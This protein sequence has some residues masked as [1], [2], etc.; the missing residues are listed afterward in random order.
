MTTGTVQPPETWKV[1]RGP[2]HAADLR[3]GVSNIAA[4]HGLT[5]FSPTQNTLV[6]TSPGDDVPR[7]T[8]RWHQ[9]T[10]KCPDTL[11]HVLP[12]A[13]H[14]EILV[15][16]S[17]GGAVAANRIETWLTR[18]LRRLDQAE[19]AH[20]VES[21]PVLDRYAVPS[22]V[23]DGWAII[24]RDHYVENSLGFLLAIERAGIPAEW[25]YA[26]S[27]G[28]RTRN[29]DR[30]HATLIDRGCASGLLDNTAV[31]APETH[32]IELAESL[33]QIDNFIDA[34]RSAGRRVLVIDDGGLIAQGYGRADALRRIDAA[35][36]LTV[37][38]LKRIAAS[39]LSIPVFN[40]ARSELKTKLGYPEI[41]D[42]CLRRLRALLPAT[43][44]T[45]RPVIVIGYGTL[46][47]RLSMTLQAQGCHVHVVDSD[48]VNL[49]A[50]AEKGHLTYRSVREALQRVTPFLI[51]GCTGGDALLPEDLDLL[52]D[53]V[54][55]APFATR[56]FSVLADP[57][58]TRS[59]KQ[60][61][62][63]GR[64]YQLNSGN[65]ATVLGDGRSL[66]LFEADAIPNQGY[67]AYRAGTLIAAVALCEQ[68]DHLPPGV[69]T[70]LVDEIIRES[71]LY[72]AYYDTYLA[73]ER[74]APA[75]T[76]TPKSYS[77][78]ALAG[79]SVCVVGYGAAGRLHAEILAAEGAELTVLDPKHQDLPRAYRGFHQGIGD[80]PHA[81]SSG[82]G[83]WSICC[84]TAD[85]LP[86]LRS[87]LAQTP[88]A[89]VLL[90]K[91]ACQGHEIDALEAL[92]DSH[93]N[94]RVAVTDQYQH[95][96]V[97]DVLN[98]LVMRFEPEAPIDHIGI[99]FTKDRTDDIA[100][101]RFIDRFYGVLGY[102]WL[103]M[104]AVLR[105]LMP[106]ESLNAYLTASP[107]RS[108]LWATYDERLFV[109]ALTERASVTTA[110]THLRVELTS[111]I[112]SP[113]VVLGST[114]RRCDDGL[115]RWQRSLRPTD[116][117]HRHITVHAGRTRFTAHLDPVTAP[118]GWQLNR[119]LH[120]VTVERG[121]E[122]LHD[123]VIEDSPLHTA[124]RQAI[125]MLTGPVTAPPP[126]LAP[127]RRIAKLA[128]FLRAQQPRR[129]E[130][131][132]AAQSRV[133]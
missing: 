60:L 118:D 90:E 81:V 130:T 73:A 24:F 72:E 25:I 87:I 115:G 54:F 126:D 28:D 120:R 2:I 9:F 12:D 43:K 66:N 80:L 86:V 95:A 10:P 52:P 122:I 20:I 55:L 116:D 131:G 93:R 3:A 56:D 78:K 31:N 119:N 34:A 83:L 30:I 123:E 47:S 38:G 15:D 62:G 48:P 89:R 100:H 59:S 94:A 88:D 74:T 108:E 29:R 91:P 42:S 35:L 67:D 64:R 51:T 58:R 111:S 77:G 53:G 44:V 71:G 128:E 97:L 27:K 107:R 21:M 33:N 103:H 75:N 102:E 96:R 113:T 92:L 37:S 82:I 26:L 50:A 84:P 18:K 117:R 40:L 132:Q 109:S 4:E 68:A 114:P 129:Q 13:P 69:H 57:Q 112:T 105:R 65:Y 124:I 1:L 5:I 19:L 104:L 32:A 70:E 49:I 61:P 39:E 6:L 22:G 127:L 46:G 125:V 41:A 79:V 7:V 11:S 16:Q 110:D 98:T 99:T 101:G 76:R 36:E 63:V 14:L 17:S 121:G 45:G 106:T 85:H 8:L 133:G 23:L